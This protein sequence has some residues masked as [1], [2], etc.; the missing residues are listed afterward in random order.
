MSTKPK[1]LTPSKIDENKPWDVYD[2]GAG[3][4]YLTAP[5]GAVLADH[6]HEAA[7]TIWVL[8][9]KGQFQIGDELFE[10]SP[11]TEIS[12]KP[13]VYHKLTVQED[14]KFIEQRK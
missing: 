10:L 12:V 2:L 11:M 4:Y 9:G 3:F 13:G 6:M 5:A 8:S 1:H 7:E 14:M